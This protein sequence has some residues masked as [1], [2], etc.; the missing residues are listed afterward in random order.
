[1]LGTTTIDYEVEMVVMARVEGSICSLR[2][3]DTTNRAQWVLKG[4]IG[5]NIFVKSH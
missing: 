3:Q 5:R 4:I 1:M 2:G